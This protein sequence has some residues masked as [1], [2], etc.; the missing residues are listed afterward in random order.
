MLLLLSLA[1]TVPALVAE[2]E[3]EGAAVA[4]TS[5][6]A[7]VR[8]S[9][10]TCSM[11]TCAGRESCEGGATRACTTTATNGPFGGIFVSVFT[12]LNK[13]QQQPPTNRAGLPVERAGGGV[14][15]GAALVP[16]AFEPRGAG[17]PRQHA[18]VRFR[19]ACASPFPPPFLLDM[20]LNRGNCWAE[21]SGFPR[22]HPPH[23]HTHTHNFNFQRRG[24]RGPL[25]LLLRRALPP[26]RPLPPPPAPSPGPRRLA[27][28]GCGG[29]GVGVGRGLA[30]A[31]AAGAASPPQG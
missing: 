30:S 2:G 19:A 9:F 8:A 21:E 11:Y 24:V 15:G 23:T 29:V 6:G 25:P 13:P 31:A 17:R 22:T 20:A 14:P 28:G 27:S 4:E 16:R 18:L 10:S 3:A 5:R 26:A 12:R 7:C 1:Q